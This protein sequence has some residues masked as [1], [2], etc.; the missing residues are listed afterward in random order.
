MTRTSNIDRYLAPRDRGDNAELVAGLQ[1]GAQS[2]FE[3]HILAVHV[4]VHKP[5]QRTRF[6]A[7]PA[8]NRGIAHL[9]LVDDPE[10][11]QSLR[12]Q[13]GLAVGGRTQRRR[14][15]NPNAHAVSA[16]AGSIRTPCSLAQASDLSMASCVPTTSRMTQPRSWLRFARRMFVAT[17]NS[18]PML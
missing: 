6:I 1:R 11:V 2:R 16:A 8:A 14:N 4:E 12:L 13:L 17:P 3:T 15:P 18:L 9:Q 10:H 5:S 7:Q